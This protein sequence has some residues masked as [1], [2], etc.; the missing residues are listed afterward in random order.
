VL[1][2]QNSAVSIG[3]ASRSCGHG[4]LGYAGDGDDLA[5]RLDD[6]EGAGQ[7]VAADQV[8]G[9]IVVAQDVPGFLAGVVDDLV[10][11]VRP[12][13]GRPAAGTKSSLAGIFATR[14]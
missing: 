12:A 9:G 8:E 6:R 11:A 2:S 4:R 14:L 10:G 1:A 13:S 7:V 5:A 3:P